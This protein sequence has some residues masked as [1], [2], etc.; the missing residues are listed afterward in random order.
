[1][2]NKNAELVELRLDGRIIRRI[3]LMGFGDPEAVE[4][5]SAG[6]YVITDEREQRLIKIHLEKDTSPSMRRMPNR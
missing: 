4:F 2:T 6:T 3:S 1:M 5:I